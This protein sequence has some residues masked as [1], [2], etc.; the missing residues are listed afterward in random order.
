MLS[1]GEKKI[2]ST[3]N[4]KK[5]S[6]Q[7]CF[8]LQI[9][10]AGGVEALSSGPGSALGRITVSEKILALERLNPTSRPTT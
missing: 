2:V 1:S 8:F 5:M 4:K 7:R 6:L 10:D 3:K 9:R